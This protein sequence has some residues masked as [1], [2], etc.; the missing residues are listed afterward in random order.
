MVEEKTIE[1]SPSPIDEP[2]KKSQ[3]P[4]CK[5]FFTRISAHKCKTKDYILGHPKQRDLF[6]NPASSHFEKFLEIERSHERKEEEKQEDHVYPYWEVDG[7]RLMAF[8]INK[9]ECFLRSKIPEFIGMNENTFNSL[10]L[11]MKKGQFETVNYEY[12]N[13][14]LCYVEMD[15][16][17]AISRFNLHQ[18]IIEPRGREKVIFITRVGLKIMLLHTNLE[19]P[20]YMAHRLFE[21]E[22]LNERNS[23]YEK[24]V[25]PVNHEEVKKLVGI[26]YANTIKKIPIDETHRYIDLLGNKLESKG[27][28]NIS[29]VFILIEWITGAE[30]TAYHPD[31]ITFKDEQERLDM[32]AKFTLE[33]LKKANWDG[34]KFPYSFQPDFGIIQFPNVKVEFFGWDDEEYNARRRIKEFIYKELKNFQLISIEKDQDSN[35]PYLI[36]KIIKALRLRRRKEFRNK[37]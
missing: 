18:E 17:E 33:I 1:Q 31:L 10:W 22:Y 14:A 28:V 2:K 34:D 11:R 24:E 27:E 21:W 6:G 7:K 23:L 9:H 26:T 12:F 35:Y 8:N 19:Y 32:R 25:F 16:Q 30:L 37:L 3:C 13:K 20:I 36:E 29:N 15:R 5:K 4:Y